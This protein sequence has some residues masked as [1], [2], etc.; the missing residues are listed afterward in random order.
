MWW[1]PFIYLLLACSA[2]SHCVKI[3]HWIRWA[4]IELYTPDTR[5]PSYTAPV[6]SGPASFWLPWRFAK[7]FVTAGRTRSAAN[8][9]GRWGDTGIR[10]SEH[11]GYLFKILPFLS[12][13][14]LRFCSSSSYL[15]FFTLYVRSSF[16]K[17]NLYSC[18]PS[19]LLSRLRFTF[20]TGHL[21]NAHE[22]LRSHA[23]ISCA[24]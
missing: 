3:F 14:F 16:S 13:S 15:V 22:S 11:V 1:L 7:R 12:A 9:L 10:Q 5:F 23:L 17:F 8:P 21:L 24:N 6:F 19:W 2:V 20:L 18:P 4:P